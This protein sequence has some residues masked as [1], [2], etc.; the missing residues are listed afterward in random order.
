VKK[1]FRIFRIILLF[2]CVAVFIASSVML[3]NILI[4]YGKADS[5]YDSINENIDTSKVEAEGEQAPARLVALAEYVSELKA[6]YPDVVG[7]VNV[8]SLGIAYPV[9]QTDN[10]DYYLTHMINGKESKSGAIFLDYRVN[11][12]PTQ[13]KNTV[14]YGHN[15][16]DGSMFH[17]IE[18][19]FS[20]RELFEG[21]VVE[22]VTENGAYL[23]TPLAIYRCEAY[24]PFHM[25][26][27]RNDE[28]FLEFC[29]MISEKSFHLTDTEYNEGSSIITFATCVNSITTKNARYIYQAVMTD[30]YSFK[31]VLE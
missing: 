13:T 4:E 7:Y 20:S 5:F 11:S 18:E 26:E 14:L 1:A 29:D 8:P 24:Y 25:Y 28:A 21:A 31:E 3:V 12:D 16:N 23:Y 6:E 2:I 9:V 27:F 10:N 17:K 22:Y 30:A 15:M 19:F